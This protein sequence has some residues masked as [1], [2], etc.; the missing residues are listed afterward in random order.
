MHESD[1]YF[2]R[3]LVPTKPHAE[4]DKLVNTLTSGLDQDREMDSYVATLKDGHGMGIASGTASPIKMMELQ[5]E[6]VI[7]IVKP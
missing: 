4:G 5:T 7:D 6:E 1:E 3:E 2:T